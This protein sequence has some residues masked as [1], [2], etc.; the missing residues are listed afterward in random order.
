MPKP[1]QGKSKQ[2]GFLVAGLVLFSLFLVVPMPATLN[3]EAQKLVAVISLMAVWW[4]GEAVPLAAT[5]LLPL[6]LYPVLGIMGT[7]EVAPNY[8]NHLIFLFLGGFFIAIAME[9][10]GLHRRLALLTIRVVGTSPS[11]IILGFMLSTAALSM[12]VSNT[13]TAM[14]MVPIA[15]AVI[16]QTTA[17]RSHFST[18]LMLGIAYAASIGGVATIIGT[19]PNTIAVG[20]IE[21]IYGQQIGFAERSGIEEVVSRAVASEIFERLP[22]SRDA[23]AELLDRGYAVAQRMSWD[24]VCSD[25][26]LP[27]LKDDAQAGGRGE[28]DR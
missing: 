7:E 10:W 4:I 2:F 21:K 20:L 1:K 27:G 22:G 14:M 3:P 25:F 19:P 15:L 18:A 6:L 5:A 9:K 17:R 13:A 26:F 23:R 8:A 28:E 12:W 11:R 24:R 16:K